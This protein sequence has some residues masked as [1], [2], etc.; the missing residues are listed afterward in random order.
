MK[1]TALVSQALPPSHSGQSLV[2]W[3]LLKSTDPGRFFLITQ[4][5]YFQYRHQEQSLPQLPFHYI[6]LRPDYQVT[7]ALMRLA[8]FLKSEKMLD[9]II[10]FKSGQIKKVFEREKPQMVIA[11][12]G[13]LFD[14]PAVYRAARELGIP[15]IFYAFD[16]YSGQWT[17]PLLHEFAEKF[18]NEIFR[19]STRVIV[20]NEFLCAEYQ[21]KYGSRAVVIHNPVDL[22][23]YEQNSP[24]KT[25]RKTKKYRI[26]YTGGVYEAHF[27]AFRN[28]LSAIPLAGIPD[29]KLD[30]F[31]PQS[32]SYLK[33]NGI[34][35]P[36]EL[37]DHLHNDRMP[38]I[39]QSAEILFLPLAFNSP[40]P[41]IINTSAPEKIGEYLASGRPILVHA[42]ADSF[43]AWYFRKYSCGYVV[44]E[45]DPRK[46]AGA[47]THLLQDKQ[48]QQN[49]AG[50][51]YVRAKKDFDVSLARKKFFA[52]L[53]EYSENIQE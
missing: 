33:K 31:C 38:E 43:I 30:L 14:P 37:H 21:K 27:D 8:S 40:Y 5:S 7:R 47:V 36:V 45:N 25:E 20:P 16:C 18:E 12:T 13:D 9:L 15:L 39:Q 50:N 35:G 28:L 42:P 51:A 3:H 22:A 23:A 19:F 48:L 2:I 17:D 44:D 11:C 10:R 4:T 24:E 26:V 32:A 41:G 52:L 29:L 34:T 49:L 1:K 6:F 53:N 46:L